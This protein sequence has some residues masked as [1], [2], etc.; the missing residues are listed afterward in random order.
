MWDTGATGCCINKNLAE[1]LGLISPYNIGLYGTQGTTETPAYLVDILMADG[2]E[3]DMIEVAAVNTKPSYD[4]IIGMN[5]IR[6]GDFALVRD[7]GSLV[8]HFNAQ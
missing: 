8:F 1:K 3:I 5:I 2:F 6:M 4:F 7:K